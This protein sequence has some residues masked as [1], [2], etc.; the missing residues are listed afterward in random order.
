M[1]ALRNLAEAIGGI[2]I[3]KDTKNPNK[4]TARMS[5]DSKMFKLLTNHAWQVGEVKFDKDSVCEV[6]MEVVIPA[7]WKK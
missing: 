7:G 2:V 6:I 1:D 4:F 5:H 3:E